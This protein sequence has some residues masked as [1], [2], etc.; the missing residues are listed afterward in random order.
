MKSAFP[1][2]LTL[3]LF[4][5]ILAI[6]ADPVPKQSTPVKTE[7]APVVQI[8]PVVQL[9]AGPDYG[10]LAE[11]GSHEK[12]ADVKVQSS[13]NTQVKMQ[14][15]SVDAKGNVLV[16]VAPPRTFTAS[17]K[18]VVSE[19][20]VLSPEGKPIRQ[21]NVKFHAQA[22]NSAPDCTV[23]VAGNGLIARF[24]KDGKPLGTPVELPHLVELSKNNAAM[25]EQA[26]K[27]LKLEKDSFATT[28]R[29]LKEILARLEAKKPEELTKTEKTQLDSYKN[30]IKF[31]EE[32]EKE[33]ANKTVESVIESLLGRVKII[34]GISV[35]EKDVFVACGENEGYGFA[36]WRFD[37]DLKNA[38]KVMSDVRGCCGQMDI[39]C[40]GVDLLVAENTKHSFARYDRDGKELSRGGKRADKDATPECFG[41]C[42][43]PM[44]VRALLGAG[45]I[46]TAES[47][48][49][50]KRFSSKGEFKTVVAAAKLTGGCKNVAVAA[51]P[52][53]KFVYLADQPGEKVII[54]R[55]KQSAEGSR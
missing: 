8:T 16:L 6:A 40:C 21:W 34:N 35:S 54:F 24:D 50:I 23:Y 27:Q 9:P 53:G 52:D 48:G 25:K 19:V 42:C 1:I 38:K 13:S 4:V 3:A 11:S 30:T 26:E 10:K 33:L 7:K 17:L 12:I 41:G 20:H 39:Q 47:E 46:L 49:I 51:S 22:I 28:S 36:I 45:D 2:T 18:D 55:E 31:Y 37:H 14:T 44:N 32:R 29:R 5:G 43:N 15:L